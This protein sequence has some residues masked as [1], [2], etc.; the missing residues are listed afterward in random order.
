MPK[1][2]QQGKPASPNKR[3]T[4]CPEWHHSFT[5][6]WSRWK[7]GDTKR[8]WCWHESQKPHQMSQLVLL[9]L[10]FC[11]SNILK[12]SCSPECEK[13]PCSR[14]H[15]RFGPQRWDSC[16][17]P[18]LCTDVT[19][20]TTQKLWMF[21]SDPDCSLLLPHVSVVAPLFCFH[22]SAWRRCGNTSSTSPTSVCSPF[23]HK[24]TYSCTHAS[25]HTHTGP[26]LISIGCSII[27]SKVLNPVVQSERP[28]LEKRFGGGPELRWVMS[29]EKPRQPFKV[30]AKA[31]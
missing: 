5:T 3:W 23:T 8:K 24:C 14:A 25:T 20:I 30:W 15:W 6:V 21:Q 28:K 11:P 26:S 7:S 18:H 17:S 19:C 27:L 10:H 16:G 31:H 1:G 29:T 9:S 12:P 22:S 13:L 4:R 2:I